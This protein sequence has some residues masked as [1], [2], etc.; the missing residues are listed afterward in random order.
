M[1]T[2][3]E[4][5]SPWGPHRRYATPGLCFYVLRLK[6]KKKL[7]T[8]ST[9]VDQK[10]PLSHEEGRNDLSELNFPLAT[11]IPPQPNTPP[12]CFLRPSE[13]KGP[14]GL[15]FLSLSL[16]QTQLIFYRL[17]LQKPF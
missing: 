10:T 16:H 9:M 15:A 4:E 3:T 14:P 7:L 6:G 5:V 17:Y 13:T 11:L 1:K 2:Q 12:M 8:R